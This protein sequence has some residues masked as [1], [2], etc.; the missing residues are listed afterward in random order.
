MFKKPF[1]PCLAVICA[2]L[3]LVLA[4]CASNSNDT[5]GEAAP[6]SVATTVPTANVQTSP[7]PTPTSTPN[8]PDPL[9][10]PTDDFFNDATEVPDE[11]ERFLELPAG[12]SLDDPES[13]D[14]FIP[15]LRD[16]LV[17]AMI[18]ENGISESSAQCVEDGLSDELLSQYLAL[19]DP[20]ASE[21]PAELEGV[22]AEMFA[23][24]ESCL[25]PEEQE[26]MG[27]TQ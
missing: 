5:P 20:D 8:E 24:Q 26:R 13:L 21:P 12:V 10:E 11:D 27:L 22:F 7:T 18:E 6:T 17:T 15:I 3:G 2:C 16:F 1:A 4:G 25:T 14:E 23:V 9:P 19:D